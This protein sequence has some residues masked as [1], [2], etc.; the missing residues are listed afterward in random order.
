[1]RNYYSGKTYNE[2]GFFLADSGDIT[3]YSNLD[4]EDSEHY[5]FIRLDTA[6][7]VPNVFYCLYSF[8]VFSTSYSEA[9]SFYI[10]NDY[11][12]STKISFHTYSGTSS[13]K[14]S[15]LGLAKSSVDLLLT[16]FDNWLND[17][18]GIRMRDVGLFPKY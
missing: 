13:M 4:S 1:M 12:S 14:D 8:S 2:Q 16:V 10:P 6:T 18:L 17:E 9:A 5:I 3:L 11:S 15:S 7:D